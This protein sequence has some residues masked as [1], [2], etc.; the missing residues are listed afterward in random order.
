MTTDVARTAEEVFRRRVAAARS[1]DHGEKLLAGLRLF[2]RACVL[3]SA[4]LRQRH[5]AAGD[6]AIRALLH[7]QVAVLRRLEARR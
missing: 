7:R 5:P 4:G 3:A 2:E 6:A 1:L